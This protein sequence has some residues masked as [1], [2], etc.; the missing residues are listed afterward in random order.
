MTIE[1]PLGHR[2][3]RA[4]ATTDLLRKFERNASTQLPENAV[5]KLIRF[6]SDATADSTPVCKLID[7]T[8]LPLAEGA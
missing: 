2:R 8:A 7:L 6:F 3:R 1:Y 4:E 5:D